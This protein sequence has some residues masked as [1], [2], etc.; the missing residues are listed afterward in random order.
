MEPD[1]MTRLAG[2]IYA[3][4][5]AERATKADWQAWADRM[6]EAG[7]T[8][9]WIIDLSLARSKE[10]AVAALAPLG[11]YDAD[12]ALGHFAIRHL[13][14][15]LPLRQFVMEASRLSFNDWAD[16]EFTNLL[17]RSNAGTSESKIFAELAPRFAPSVDEAERQWKEL[18]PERGE[19]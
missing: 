19:P 14:S 10:Q 13:Y 18:F 4:V 6:I 12:A 5:E 16:C 15:P 3:A 7:V 2:Y 8:P 17:D 9:D 11:T 1:C